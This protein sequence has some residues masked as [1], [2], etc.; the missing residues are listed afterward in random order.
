MVVSCRNVWKP[1]TT[2]D[3]LG[4]KYVDFF[5]ILE[6][7]ELSSYRPEIHTDMRSFCNNTFSSSV[8]EF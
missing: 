1:K 7:I 6:G 8:F 2:Q 4:E 5:E 3:L